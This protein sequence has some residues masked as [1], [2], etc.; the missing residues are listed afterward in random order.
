MKE[1]AEFYESLRRIKEEK[2]RYA[3]MVER[4]YEELRECHP[5]WE[6]RRQAALQA[7]CWYH[8]SVTFLT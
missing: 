6:M 5:E 7:Y 1:R 2:Q 4:F 3:E 8:S